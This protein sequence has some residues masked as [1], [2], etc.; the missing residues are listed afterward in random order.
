[1]WH[2]GPPRNEGRSLLLCPMKAISSRHQNSPASGDCWELTKIEG[3]ILL[4]FSP[5][6]MGISMNSRLSDGLYVCCK[7]KALGVHGW[8]F[9]FRIVGLQGPD[10]ICNPL[11]IAVLRVSSGPL[12]LK[13]ST[14]SGSRDYWFG[15]GCSKLRLGIKHWQWFI[16]LASW[17]GMVAQPSLKRG[18]VH[19]FP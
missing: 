8:P 2:P 10:L 11:K 14:R 13:E 6:R 18:G 12:N 15:G 3:H 4:K 16:M 17:G 7:G 1:M 19:F 5:Y 9:V